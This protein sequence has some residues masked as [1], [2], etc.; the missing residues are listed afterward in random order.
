MHPILLSLVTYL[1]LAGVVAILLTRG[2][3]QTVETAARWV[4]LWTSG[5]VFALAVVMWVESTPR[6]LASSSRS[7]WAGPA[8]PVSPTMPG[9][10]VSASCSCCC[11][12]S[13][14]RCPSSGAGGRSPGA[15]AIT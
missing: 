6:A 5:I 15:C 14:P 7:R 11:P 10:T 4:A 9:W 13:L 12:P 8:G 2:T 3:P 1:P